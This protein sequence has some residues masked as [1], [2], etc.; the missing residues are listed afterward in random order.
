MTERLIEIGLGS[1]LAATGLA[2]FA[3][4]ADRLWPHRPGFRRGLWLLVLLKLLVPAPWSLRLP[5][6]PAQEPS[7]AP[8]ARAEESLPR[9]QPRFEPDHFSESE[10]VDSEPAFVPP[11]SEPKPA[12]VADRASIRPRISLTTW[13]VGIWALGVMSWA[14]VL[15]TRVRRVKC[16]L[17]LGVAPSEADRA[18]LQHCAERLG[19]KRAPPVTLVPGAIS[20]MLWGLFG[21]AAIVLPERLWKRFDTPRREAILLHELAHWKHRDHWVRAGELLATGLYWW[22]PPSRWFCRALRQAEEQCR[23]GDVVRAQADQAAA[24]SYA[25]ALLDVV[26]FLSE[27]DAAPP[28]IAA[29][30]AGRATTLERR[31]VM[32]LQSPSNPPRGL[33]RLG[34][35]ALLT[36]GGAS[37]PFMPEFVA[38]PPAN[39]PTASSAQRSE[40]EQP[41]EAREESKAVKIEQPLRVWQGEEARKEWEQLVE[42]AK[43]QGF[44]KPNLTCSYLNSK[45]L[46]T[47]G[48]IGVVT[49]QLREASNDCRQCHS[50]VQVVT[51][52]SFPGDRTD[53][54]QAELI[55]LDAL[56]A[57]TSAKLDDMKTK[58]SALA[59]RIRY[60]QELKAKHEQINRELE[61]HRREAKAADGSK[62]ASIEALIDRVRRQ[63]QEFEAIEQELMHLRERVENQRDSDTDDDAEAGSE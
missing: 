55:Q 41:A 30:G 1:A 7:R 54:L 35:L 22:F 47:F 36:I 4:S 48:G 62:P 40:A 24:K 61:R 33:T 60:E 34:S 43:Q 58:R 49:T 27:P 2:L 39:T 19:L 14:A 37:L 20:P 29:T 8:L 13:A 59:E 17:R 63:Q 10:S 3:W 42:Q 11:R 45:W 53:D 57:E 23:D 18:L 9:E 6:R 51:I 21:S 56:I 32:I 31:L 12:P 46:A 52:D 16:W 15:A 50:N 28:P 5:V 25:Q 26:D 38:V 44:D